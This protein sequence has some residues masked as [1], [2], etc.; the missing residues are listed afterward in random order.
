MRDLGRL[1]A[2]RN[3]TSRQSRGTHSLSSAR[4]LECPALLP[5]PALTPAAA[6]QVIRPSGGGTTTDSTRVLAR[7]T[8]PAGHA[9]I[10]RREGTT[11]MTTMTVTE[12]ETATATAIA[13]GG[14]ARGTSTTGG[15]VDAMTAA[16][17]GGATVIAIEITTMTGR[18]RRGARVPATATG[19]SGPV[20]AT[21]TRHHRSANA[22]ALGETMTSTRSSETLG[23]VGT[24][25]IIA[26]RMTTRR[27]GAGT[28]PT[29]ARR[30]IRRAGHARPKSRV[31]ETTN[32]VESTRLRCQLSSTLR[33]E[34]R[35]C[36]QRIQMGTPA[37]APARR[38]LVL[39]LPL[40][41]RSSASSGSGSKRG[42]K[43]RLPRRLR[44]AVQPV[45]RRLLR[46]SLLPLRSHQ[47]PL[48]Q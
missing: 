7:R 11:E 15:L 17:T 3:S 27:G 34:T 41:K 10:R 37:A 36:R 26:T 47:H 31:D 6:E 38:L 46:Q 32:A 44:P 14:E 29:T 19:T 12:I 13:I 48:Q 1:L 21:T 30:A 43:R 9:G 20:G 40:K 42:R 45:P 2:R 8:R 16:E 18:R 35:P 5:R 33:G 25:T 23:G 22:H 39:L 28:M 4:P 24:T